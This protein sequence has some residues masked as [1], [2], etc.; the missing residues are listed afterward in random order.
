MDKLLVFRVLIIA[1]LVCLLLWDVALWLS[2]ARQPWPHR[3]T[4]LTCALLWIISVFFPQN[5][6]DDWQLT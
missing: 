6:N 1:V 4:L 2:G 5:S 3:N